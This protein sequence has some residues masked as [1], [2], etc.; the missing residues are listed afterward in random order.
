MRH[1]LCLLTLLA[2]PA[3]SRAE[4]DPPPREAPEEKPFLVLDTGG[5]TAPV[6][7]ILFTPDG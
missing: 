7:K 5:H 3:L 1:L 2:V 4:A 6:V